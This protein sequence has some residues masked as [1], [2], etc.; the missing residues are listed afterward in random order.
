ME[1]PERMRTVSMCGA[2]SLGEDND[3]G[4]PNSPVG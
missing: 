4:V 3:D 2:V 1:I